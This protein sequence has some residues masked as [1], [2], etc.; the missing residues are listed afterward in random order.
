MRFYDL[1]VYTK[2]KLLNDDKPKGNRIFK[3]TYNKYFLYDGFNFKRVNNCAI[4]YSKK[5]N[6]CYKP[7][8]LDENTEVI[9]VE[10]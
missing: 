3:K 9:K 7:I 10:D 8:Y 4:I 5:Y 1:P 2:F 6:D